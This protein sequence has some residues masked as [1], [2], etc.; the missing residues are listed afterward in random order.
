MITLVRVAQCRWSA[1][2]A[3]TRLIK[4]HNFVVFFLFFLLSSPRAQVA[5]LD[6]FWRSTS[7]RMFLAKDVRLVFV[8]YN[9]VQGVKSPKKLHKMDGNRPFSSVNDECEKNPYML[10]TGQLIDRINYALLRTMR[11][12]VVQI[13]YS[14]LRH[15]GLLINAHNFG[16]N[17]QS[18]W[19]HLG[20]WDY[21]GRHHGAI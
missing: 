7:K 16:K 10:K 2:P 12:T 3:N 5:F 15:I 4:A 17:R 14:S 9:Y 19:R 18:Y 11:L 20:H 6:Q 8:I 1:Q 13:Q 21:K